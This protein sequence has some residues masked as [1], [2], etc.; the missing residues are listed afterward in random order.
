MKLTGKCKEDF[1]KWLSNDFDLE[2]NPITINA[3]YEGDIEVYISEHFDNLSK[4]MQYGVYVDFF[5]S[6]GI[7]I[8]IRNIGDS[9]WYV[10]NIHYLCL[11]Q[12]QVGL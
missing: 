12:M 7:R 6:V 8:S 5:D 11:M 1:Y 2:E 4:S 3:S 10:I 9:Y